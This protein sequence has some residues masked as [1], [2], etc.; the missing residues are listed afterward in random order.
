MKKIGLLE[1]LR[2]KPVICAEGFLFEAERRGYMSSGEFVPKIALE[3]PDALRN[4]HL[5][6]QH[7]GSDVVLAFTYNGHREKMRV[8]NEEHLLEP[9]NRTALQIAKQVSEEIT[10]DEP[11]DLLEVDKLDPILVESISAE[12]MMKYFYESL[13]LFPL[14]RNELPELMLEYY[15]D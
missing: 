2:N 10:F 14:A 13:E 12:D 5:D 1:R 15:L 8:I 6:F 3:N 7:A 9:L 4:I 11:K